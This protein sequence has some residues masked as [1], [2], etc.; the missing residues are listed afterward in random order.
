[1]KTL[2]SKLTTVLIA[3]VA[4]LLLVYAAWNWSAS[5]SLRHTWDDMREEGLPVSIADITPVRVP[6]GDNA[7]PFLNRAFAAMARSAPETERYASAIMALLSYQ[8]PGNGYRDDAPVLTTLNR[9]Q[10]RLVATQLAAPEAVETFTLLDQA[11]RKPRCDFGLDYAGGA[12]VLLP[13]LSHLRNAVHLLALKAWIQA[14]AGDTGPALQTLIKALRISNFLRREPILVSQLVR[15][16]ANGKALNVLE[17]ILARHAPAAFP[18]A[19]LTALLAQLEAQTDPGRQAFVRALDG[20]RVLFGNWAFSRLIVGKM[21]ADELRSLGM[22]TELSLYSSLLARPWVKT[23]FRYY[24]L[25]MLEHRRR[26]LRP[27]PDVAALDPLSESVPDFYILTRILLPALDRI[28]QHATTNRAHIELARLALLLTDYA[29]QNNDRYPASLKTL[30]LPVDS[31]RDPFTAT[32]L[33]YRIQ[34][35]GYILY[36]RGPDLDDDDGEA[37]ASRREL[38]RDGDLVWSVTSP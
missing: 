15:V 8:L 26:L 20:E 13:H 30:Q 36:S 27:Y 11:V 35:G 12:G 2:L 32:P 7:A 38:T 24:L 3:L 1:M 6:P 14:D 33:R 17:D 22:R 16:A 9:E 5:R 23:D 34:D 21:K 37:P 28:H 31:S 4:V 29:K 18:S 25:T 19:D 10:K